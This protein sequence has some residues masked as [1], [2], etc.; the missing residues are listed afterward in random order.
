VILA[1][2]TTFMNL[3]GQ[4]VVELM[5][6]YKVELDDIVV[7]HD[8]LDLPLGTIRVKRG[9]GD[10]GNNGLRHITRALS[11]P[12]YARV[13]I[14]IGRPP[15][16]QKAADHVLQPFAKTEEPEVAVLV[17]E[18]ADITLRLLAEPLETVQNALHGGAAD[19]P[20]PR[21]IKRQIEI[22]APIDAVWGA[23]ET[24]EE[25][26]SSVPHRAR[27]VLE[28]RAPNRLSFTWNAPSDIPEVF[29]GEPTRV[30][31]ALRAS[32]RERTR[33]TLSH[34][35]WKSGAAWDDAFTYFENAW[36]RVLE[37][38]IQRFAGDGGTPAG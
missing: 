5:R 22:A 20:K 26:L 30:D 38:L 35:G 1:E 9:G 18:A 8:E 17:E 36:T 25:L 33:V 24:P 2:P 34:S 37:Q 21:R 28:A 15:G 4:A 19:A 32:G 27:K 3:S 29:N 7:V 23:W 6:Y 13:R 14:G 31:I 10:A 12:E 16:R 11:T